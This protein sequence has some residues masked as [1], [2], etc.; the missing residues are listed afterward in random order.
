MHIYRRLQ[1]PT[2]ESPG[3]HPQKCFLPDSLFPVWPQN[4]NNEENSERNCS[5]VQ[6]KDSKL[7]KK[8]KQEHVGEGINVKQE[9]V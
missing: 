3:V 4:R 8:T 5:C 7:E 9:T 1:H 6:N 2:P